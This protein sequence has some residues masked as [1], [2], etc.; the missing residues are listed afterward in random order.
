MTFHKP[1]GEA[2]MY[3]R[4]VHIPQKNCNHTRGQG[5]GSMNADTVNEIYT[6]Q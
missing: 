2:N 5:S 3:L 6:S 1:V 4:F